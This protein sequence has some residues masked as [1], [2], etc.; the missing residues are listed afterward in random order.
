MLRSLRTAPHLGLTTPATPAL[1]RIQLSALLSIVT[2]CAA[3]LDGA[4]QPAS[5]STG[6]ESSTQASSF[7]SVF[8]DRAKGR[9][10]I[11]LPPADERGVHATFLMLAGIETGLG[12][13]DVGLDRGQMGGARLVQFRSVGGRI[14]LEEINT[15]FRAEAGSSLEQEAARQS[16]ATSVLFGAEPEE[17]SRARVDVT[18][19]IVRDAHG[20]AE[21]LKRTG[22]GTYKLASDR[23]GLDVARCG[24][25]PENIEFTALLTFTSS[26][27]GRLA[28]ATA[29]D[30]A[31]LSFIQ[32]IGF[33]QLPD[34]GYERRRFDPRM[35]AFS[36][37]YLDYGVDLASP[38]EQRLAV[39]H[40]IR[41]DPSTG[42]A[43]PIV[44]YVDRAAPEPIRSAL[45]EGASWW[46]EAFAD[47]GYPNLFRV[48]VAPEGLD[49]LDVRHNVIQWVHR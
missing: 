31:A 1:R 33:V 20:I 23:S 45:V 24:A 8:F 26:S 12:A 15:S 42:E 29:P 2:A 25:F 39:R 48:E 36:T 28:R 14:L 13:N 27:P 49:P 3:P 41:R 34:N 11:D 9:A 18:G 30:G 7:L 38:I 10:F 32:R 16:F 43:L 37:S 21:T 4:S 46:G 40:R 47:A 22:Q 44:Y 17:G 35:G 6:P 19:L 5:G